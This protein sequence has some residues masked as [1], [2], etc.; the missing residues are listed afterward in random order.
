MS[1]G[2]RSQTAGRGDADTRGPGGFGCAP[3]PLWRRGCGRAGEATHA[4]W[5]SGATKE[6]CPQRRFSATWCPLDRDRD[7]WW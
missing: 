5:R 6:G 3:V 4:G 7:R 1:N 2:D